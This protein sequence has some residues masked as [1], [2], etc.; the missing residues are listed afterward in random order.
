MSVRS[1]RNTRAAAFAALGLSAALALTGCSSSAPAETDTDTA[2]S[3][4]GYY[5]VT[6]TDMA[7]NEVTI[8]SAESVAITDNRFFQLAADWDLPITA[9][10]VDLM[11]PNNPLIDDTGI[12]NLGT[13]NEPDFEKLV[14]ADPDLIINGYRFSGDTEKGV[15]DAAPDAAFVSMDVPED[16]SASEYTAQSL[17]LMGKVFNREAEAEKLTS[18]F[19]E[20]VKKAKD[21]YDPETTVLGVLTAGGEVN[22]SN[23]T[24]GRGAS[25]FFSLLDLTPALDTEG[26]TSHTGDEVSIEALAG[27]D[28]D[29][30]LVLDRDAAAGEGEVKPA[31][32]VIEGST[33]LAKLPAVKN[34]A[35]YIMPD[36]YYVTEDV[37]A[38]IAVLNGL[39]EVFE[40]QK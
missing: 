40:A 23:P 36:D 4:D 3:A 37:F 1:T 11:S 30:L 14:E 20:A 21:A 32:E 27:T 16:M 33:A 13:H 25:V 17:D 7:G 10:P 31:V 35:I 6:V 12:L 39:A 5:P 8:E 9:A 26:S 15:K 22:Y 2:A 19:E 18:E 38:Y 29:V 24:D 34:D 28:A